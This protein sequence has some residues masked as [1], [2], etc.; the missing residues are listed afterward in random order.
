MDREKSFVEVAKEIEEYGH[1]DR[2]KKKG[3]V[4]GCALILTMIVY[5]LAQKCL[6]IR[7][8]GRFFH[9]PE[10]EPVL[11]GLFGTYF[12]LSHGFPSY[13]CITRFVQSADTHSL[14]IFLCEWSYLFVPDDGQTMRLWGIDGQAVRAGKSQ[15]EGGHPPYNVDFYDAGANILVYLKT[16]MKKSLESVAAAE[17]INDVLFGH[18]NICIGADAM[19]TKKPV[20]QAVLMSGCNSMLPV[21]RNNPKLMNGFIF[22]LEALTLTDS[23]LVDHY[24]DLN[25]AGDGEGNEV[26]GNTTCSYEEEDNK[27]YDSP[28]S[29]PIKEVVFFDH[30]YPYGCDQATTIKETEGLE[31]G[32]DDYDTVAGN[33]RRIVE[34]QG[35]TE[36]E[37]EAENSIE[38]TCDRSVDPAPVIINPEATG[39]WF[40][41]GDRYVVMTPSHG[42]YERRE[43]ELL[44]HPE[45]TD[46][47]E[48]LPIKLRQEWEPYIKT[49]GM[50]TRYR[51]TLNPVREGANA[52]EEYTITVTRTPYM[53]SF[54]PESAEVFEK[55]VREYWGIENKLHYVVD[56]L[57]GQDRC[58]CRVGN[59]TGNMSLLRKITYNIISAARNALAAVVEEK[60]VSHA[61][62]LDSLSGN[63]QTTMRLL[64]GKPSRALQNYAEVH[65]IAVQ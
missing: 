21:K 58:T 33:Q 50:V 45:E 25:G 1:V 18:E 31:N 60:K 4:H 11:K 41:V 17:C 54:V 32:N 55:L 37:T 42:R 61:H 59:S 8:V 34:A 62:V 48:T 3:L 44:L 40:K 24:V 27:K 22:K 38:K 29:R 2:R 39:K 13:S 28:K 52:A 15:K 35:D 53:L 30:V 20:L 56:D 47:W 36:G 16:V 5:G 63:L 14:T 12:D 51:A 10:R 9:D 23:H 19:M 64:S 65:C 6:S 26:I 43:V 7:S 49:I 57:L 46:I